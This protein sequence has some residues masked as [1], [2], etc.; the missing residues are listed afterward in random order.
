MLVSSLK[1]V[2]R[3]VQRLRCERICLRQP[4]PLA[5]HVGLIVTPFY[6]VEGDYARAGQTAVEVEMIE[7]ILPIERRYGIR[8]TYNIVGRFAA[9]APAT[10]AAIRDAGQEIAS[11]SYDHSIL[12]TL[13]RAAIAENARRAKRAFADLGVEIR[14][15]RS[16][17]SDWD[18][19]VVD[20]LAA[21]GYTWNAENGPEPYP[22]RLRETPQGGLWRFAV[23]DDDWWYEAEGYSP[24]AMLERLQNVV[25]ASVGH[26]KHI[27]IG[28]HAWV[29]AGEGR[30][31]ALEAFYRWLASQQD[32]QVLS[33]GDVARLL[34]NA[35]TSGRVAADA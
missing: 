16:P 31:A 23:A 12:S 19:R 9:D 22:Y 1:R 13:S 15:H 8:S 14:G 33:F 11:H 17:Q 30:L 18:D 21:Y 7:R 27:G 5:G 24:A 6:D 29:E 2:R 26:R 4:N 35:T 25:R 28:F 10:V 32:V 34:T 20:A 3:K